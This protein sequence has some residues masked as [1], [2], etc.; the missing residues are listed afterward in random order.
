MSRKHRYIVMVPVE[1]TLDKPSQLKTA[2]RGIR[3]H[4]AFPALESYGEDCYSWR[5]RHDLVRLKNIRKQ[6]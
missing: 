3:D 4:G 2:F 5:T 6:S 1:I